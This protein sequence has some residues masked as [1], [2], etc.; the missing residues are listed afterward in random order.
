MREGYFYCF[1]L[2]LALFLDAV[3]QGQV[4]LSNYFSG[5]EQS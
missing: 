1:G 5:K 2:L 4:G 3:V